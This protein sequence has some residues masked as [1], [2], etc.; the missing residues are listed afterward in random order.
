MTTPLHLPRFALRSAELGRRLDIFLVCAVGVGAR[1]PG[2]PD[3]HRLPA[4]RQ[5]HAAHLARDLGRADDGDRHRVR[6]VVPGAEQPHVHRVHRRVRLR[7]VHRRAGQV[8]HPRRQLLLQA[9][10]RAHLHDLHRD[11]PG[12]PDDRAAGLRARRGG[13]QRARGAEGRRA[14]PAGGAEAQ[15]RGRRCS[16]RPVPTHRSRTRCARCSPTSATCPIPRPD[17]WSRW[18]S[19]VRARY[20]G[21]AEHRWFVRAVTWLFAILGVGALLTALAARRSTTAQLH[22]FTEWA[23]TISTGVSGAAHR[24]RPVP[25]PARPPRRPT[26]GSSAGVLVQIFVTQVFEFASQELA[27]VSGLIANIALWLALR[28]MIRAE[29]ERTHSLSFG[30]P[31]ADSHA[32][33]QNGGGWGRVRRL[34][35]PSAGSDR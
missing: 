33:R 27:G 12:V 22:G 17:R 28:S 29:V 10:H 8:H 15:R 35:Q 1:E 11:V 4:A 20:L 5:R 7:L 14:R 16:T 19:A 34:T 24:D 21:L 30:A 26:A 3:H 18:G 13:A 32:E 2:V 31:D 25:D 6:A 9:H 23:Y